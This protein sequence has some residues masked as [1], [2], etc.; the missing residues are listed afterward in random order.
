MLELRFSSG[1]SGI[2]RNAGDYEVWG[3]EFLVSA[4]IQM[5]TS[6]GNLF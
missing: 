1:L 6:N 3:H 4:N 2:I 5:I